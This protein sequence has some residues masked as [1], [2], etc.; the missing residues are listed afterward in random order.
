M[1]DI[2]PW[3]A[4]EMGEDMKI[5]SWSARKMGKD[6]KIL[7]ILLLT[8]LMITGC[9]SPDLDRSFV[10][11]AQMSLKSPTG[12]RD[13]SPLSGLSARNKAGGGNACSV[14]AQ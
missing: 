2:P 14:C 8:H 9:A 6:M 10:N 5:L 12:I 3:N 13:V 11:D 1:N 4:R 7:W